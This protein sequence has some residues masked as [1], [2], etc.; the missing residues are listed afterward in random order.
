MAGSG[1]NIRM[2]LKGI[3]AESGGA[4][5]LAQGKGDTVIT[6][7]EYDSRKVRE[8][9]LF[10]AVEGLQSDGHAFV[11]RA[12]DAGAGAVLISSAKAG[13]FS[14]LLRRG[15]DVLVSDNT[16]HALSAVSAA[17]YSFPS[18]SLKVFGVT[19]TNGKTSITYMLESIMKAWGQKP[20]VIGT[21]NYRWGD[22]NMD[23]PNTTPE[24]RDLQELLYTMKSDGTDTVIMEVSSHA[25]DLNRADSIDFDV[26][27][28][29]NLTRD[30]LD[31]H[32]TFENYFNAKKKLFGLVEQSAKQVK[33]AVVNADDSYGAEILD[34]GSRYSYRF[35][36]FGF[37]KS[38]EYR[39]DPSSVVSGVAG[40]RY[41]MDNPHRGALIELQ[42]AG[43][44][45]VYNSLCA[46]AAADQ[47]GV[48]FEVIQEGL[49][50]LPAV[51]GRFHVIPSKLGFCAVVDYAHTGDALQKLLLSARD[52]EPARIITVFGCGGD[53]DKG[54][55]PIMGK[56]A[57]E[58]SDIVVI[59]SD[60]PRT[61]EPKA[62]IND[63]IA[64]LAKKN[65]TVIVEREDAI[66]HAIRIAKEGDLIVIAGK[67][68]EDYQIIGTT[69]T[70]FDDCDI[71]ER[72]MRE[73]EAQ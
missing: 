60:N 14:G 31:Y 27:M 9:S 30:H 24:S 73:R 49:R 47:A 45:H 34:G 40:V 41:L 20:G 5:S 38:A 28:F 51:P 65:H 56:I 58:A 23:A 44:F 29:T 12:V 67:G 63:I 55:R 1:S 6:A 13:E 36:G 10:V 43:R 25:L 26:A 7:V 68:H 35:A 16:R 72:Y 42:V 19:G 18:R 32:G 54:K 61:E 11:S 48:P 50:N 3:L 4:Y 33:A 17:F 46:L 62:I 39:P 69:K 53:R 57:E 2:T 8:G 37:S 21:V 15:V 52:L 70:H 22:R 59:T 71:A 64:G 66:H